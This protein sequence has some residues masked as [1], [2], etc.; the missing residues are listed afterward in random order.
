MSKC[1]TKYFSLIVLLSIGLSCNAPRNNPLDPENPDHKFSII[2]GI[3]KTVKVP[4]IPIIGV[5][6]IWVNSGNIVY[7]NSNGYFKLENIA[8]DDGY[9]TIEKERYD[10]DSLFISFNN[11][12]RIS[13]NIFLNATPKINELLFYSITINK[14]PSDQN[15]QLEVKANITDVEN[16]IDSVFIGN[17]ELNSKK[18][19][20]FNISSK[21]Y[22]N[23]ISL[24]DLNVTS[25]DIVIGKEFNID[26][27]DSQSKKFKIGTS[28][29]K[30]IIKAEIEPTAPLGRD[31]VYSANPILEWRKFSPGF[32]FNYLLEIYTAE[33][34]PILVW[35]EEISSS[36]ISLLTD[37][38]LSSG[39]YFWVIWAI[40]EFKNRTRS[41]ESSFIIN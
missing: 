4:Q 22:E 39:D 31:T 3:V 9:L 11:Q 7:S 37:A 38:N 5:K 1:F 28:F 18:E 20:L 25:I 2:E 21:Y 23:T 17:L 15:Y 10:V 30:R 41:K 27:L 13:K 12:S 8:R 16:D 34:T 26:V 6:I 35:H 40:D 36:E 33:V 24:E 14:F 32:E 29:I 19:L